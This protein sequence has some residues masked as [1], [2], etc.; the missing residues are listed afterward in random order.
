[1]KRIGYL[2][3]ASLLLAAGCGKDSITVVDS[4]TI[5][6]YNDVD[7]DQTVTVVY[8]PTGNATVSG[9]PSDFTVSID[10]NGVTII[11]TGSE[12][13]QYNLTGSSSNGYFKLYSPTRQAVMLQSLTLTNPNGPALN[14]QGPKYKGKVF[15]EGDMHDTARNR[16]N[17]S[18]IIRHTHPPHFV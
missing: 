6:D 16:H 12:E 1:M 5:E 4:E 2:L 10:G 14:L 3:F 17:L 8:S 13:V 7:F 18:V 11:Y 15:V 9:T